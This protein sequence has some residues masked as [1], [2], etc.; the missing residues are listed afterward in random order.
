MYL[1]L[2]NNEHIVVQ[3]LS[4]MSEV[5]PLFKEKITGEILQFGIQSD[6]LL[7]WGTPYTCSHATSAVNQITLPVY[8][9]LSFQHSRMLQIVLLHYFGVRL[10]Q[11][12]H[13][14]IFWL[15]LLPASSVAPY[16]LL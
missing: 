2:I 8:I 3:G 6:C 12:D 15:Q 1:S 7:S 9:R 10:L 5:G 4:S 13:C 11:S 14:R 16:V